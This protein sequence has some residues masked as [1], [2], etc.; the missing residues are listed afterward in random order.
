VD[1]DFD[2]FLYT[3]ESDG[4]PNVLLEAMSHGYVAIAPN[5]GGIGELVNEETGFLVENYDDVDAYVAIL[6]ELLGD[7]N[8]LKNKQEAL[9]KLLASRFSRENFVATMKQIGML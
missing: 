3:S 7:K 1:P 5:V 2:V 4:I 9:K 8:L 6:K